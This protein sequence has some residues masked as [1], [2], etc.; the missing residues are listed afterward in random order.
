VNPFTPEHDLFRK[1]VRDFVTREM[2]PFREEWEK[3]REVPRELYKKMG[4][5]GFLGIR[6]PEEL[7]GSGGDFWYTVAFCEELVKGAR[8]MGPAVNIQVDIDMAT[9]IINIL[10]TEEQK[11]EFLVPVIKGDKIAALGITEPE[12]GSDV[13]RIRTTAK[14]EGDHY[15]INGSKTFITN[16]SMGDIITLA[17]R[18]GGEGHLGLSLMLFSTDTPG[19]SVGRKLEKMGNHSSDTA[20]LHF[21]NCKVPAKNLLGEENKGFY[22][23]MKNFQGERLIIAID[24]IALCELIWEE[25][26]K[27]MT[28][29]ETF[30]K[31]LLGHQAL[32]HRMVDLLTEIEAS[33]RL[34]YHAADLFNQQVECT[35]EIS[36]AKLHAGELVNKV[37]LQCQQMF[38]GYGYMEEY[39]IVRWV[40]DARVVNIVGGTSDIMKEIIGKRL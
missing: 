39:E 29:R 36:M 32:R 19:F 23:I 21:E 34:V 28:E 30:G 3:T 1:T 18:T 20:E 8:I 33:K 11:Q 14:K 4:D 38:G 6:Y 12:A 26:H 17:V 15:I 31:P 25:T 13:A 5:L 2:T 27:Y 40:Q 22:Y 24:A 7:G 16:G 9:P 10:G 37:T 35:R